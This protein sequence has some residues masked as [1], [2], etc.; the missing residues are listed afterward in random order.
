[1]NISHTLLTMAEVFFGLFLIWGF[2]HEEKVIEWE[3]R[4]LARMGI[5]RRRRRSAKITRFE[6]TL[7][8]REKNCI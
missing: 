3:D 4:L 7:N 6:N 1:M 2:W 8:H 5:F